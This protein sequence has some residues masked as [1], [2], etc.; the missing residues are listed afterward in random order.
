MRALKVE[1][2]RESASLLHLRRK[3]AMGVGYIISNPS[4][5]LTAF[6][7]LVVS[8]NE[9]KS[10]LTNRTMDRGIRSICHMVGSRVL[11]SV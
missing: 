2:E 1:A 3:G 5:S 7:G 9:G 4:G 8:R 10:V 11:V 6:F